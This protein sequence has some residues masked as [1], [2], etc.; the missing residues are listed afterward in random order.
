MQSIYRYKWHENADGSF[1]LGRYDG[2]KWRGWVKQESEEAKDAMA[3]VGAKPRP[4]H[5]EVCGKTIR[6]GNLCAECVEARGY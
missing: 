3:L 2:D 1:H 6:Y 4:D 5:C